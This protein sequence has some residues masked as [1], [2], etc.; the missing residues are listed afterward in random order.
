VLAGRYDGS[1]QQK[2]AAHGTGRIPNKYSDFRDTR[3]HRDLDKRQNFGLAT[4]LKE[5]LHLQ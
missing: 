4:V 2:P 3:C 1:P 5:A